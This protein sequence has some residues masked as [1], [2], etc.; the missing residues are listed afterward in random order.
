MLVMMLKKSHMQWVNAFMIWIYLR[1]E[2][3]PGGGTLVLTTG[4]SLFLI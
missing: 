3:C 2:S 4:I 1:D